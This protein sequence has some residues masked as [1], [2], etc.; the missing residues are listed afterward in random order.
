MKILALALLAALGCKAKDKECPPPPPP[1]SVGVDR[2][3]VEALCALSMT[4]PGPGTGSVAAAVVSNGKERRPWI[5]REYDARFVPIEKLEEHLS[6]I[7]D[8][9]PSLYAG[10]LPNSLCVPLKANPR[11]VLIS[12]VVYSATNGGKAGAWIVSG[13]LTKPDKTFVEGEHLSTDDLQ[14]AA[15][16]PVLALLGKGTHLEEL[17]MDDAGDVKGTGVAKDWNDAFRE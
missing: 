17:Q 2:D 14:K 15:V 5:A 10:S 16:K 9:S 13:L 8:A 3:L 7:K 11:P 1:S 12:F 4:P 6:L